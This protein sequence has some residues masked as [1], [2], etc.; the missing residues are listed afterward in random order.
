WDDIRGTGA[1]KKFV[2]QIA[3]AVVL[4]FLGYRIDQIATPFGHPVSLGILALPFTVLWI[5][6]VINALN[7]I[8]GMDG[9]ASGVALFAVGATF[10]IAFFRGDALM[11][12]L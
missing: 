3:L 6:G 7:L 10:L 1:A 5:V 4:Y 12:M 2:V 9:L 8:D 11:M